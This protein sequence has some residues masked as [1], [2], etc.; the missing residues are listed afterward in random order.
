MRPLYIL[1]TAFL[2]AA[3][4]IDGAPPAGQVEGS[5]STGGFMPEDY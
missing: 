3:C 1:L 4:G 2:I 5:P